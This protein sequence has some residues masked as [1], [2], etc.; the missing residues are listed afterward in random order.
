MGGS[1]QRGG[2][3]HRRRASWVAS[4]LIKQVLWNGHLSC[5]KVRELTR[6]VT[7]DT[8]QRWCEVARHLTAGQLAKL[9]AAGRRH[10]PRRL[11][12]PLP[13]FPREIDAGQAPPTGSGAALPAPVVTDD[14]GGHEHLRPP[15]LSTS[16]GPRL[17][18][19]IGRRHPLQADG[20]G[21]ALP[22]GDHKTSV[23]SGRTTSLRGTN[24][25]DCE[26]AVG[27]HPGDDTVGVPHLA[28]VEFIAAPHR[29]GNGGHRGEYSSGNVEV[30]RQPN[31][32]ANGLR[33]IRDHPVEPTS[34]LIPKHTKPACGPRSDRAS[35]DGATKLTTLVGHWRLFDHI[36]AFGRENLESSV[37]QIAPLPTMEE[38]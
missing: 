32:P 35:T 1:G 3:P 2:V 21:R 26:A 12:T 9:V 15:R 30:A 13:D 22:P 27:Q 17:P 37:I 28:C 38:R 25:C 7:A 16:S 18:A 5:S 10:R 33:R 6:V 4:R 14:G 29:R 19:E 23:P 24:F 20:S 31:R 34:D 36:P 11:T 8:E